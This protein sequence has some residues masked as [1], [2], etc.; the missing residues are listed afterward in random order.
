M[1]KKC[2]KPAI[3]AVEHLQDQL[4]TKFG[5]QEEYLLMSLLNCYI[6]NEQISWMVN[7]LISQFNIL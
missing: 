1:I 3:H 5:E 2:I 4:Y 6:P 7:W